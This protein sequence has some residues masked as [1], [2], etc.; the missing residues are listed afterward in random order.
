[1]LKYELLYADKEKIQELINKQRKTLAEV[2]YLDLDSIANIAKGESRNKWKQ[3]FQIWLCRAASYILQYISKNFEN[4][5]FETEKNTEDIRF[6]M[7]S[8][9]HLKSAAYIPQM[10]GNAVFITEE[11]NTKEKTGFDSYRYYVLGLRMG[12]VDYTAKL[13]VGVKDGEAYYDHA[14]TEIEKNS[15]LESIDPINTGF[16]NK[17]DAV[18][19]VKD[20]R[21]LSLLQTNSSKVVDENGEPRVVY[22][23]TNESFLSFDRNKAGISR[24][25]CER[26]GRIGRNIW[27]KFF[28]ERI[29]DSQ[30]AD[31]RKNGRINN[32]ENKKSYSHRRKS[33]KNDAYFGFEQN[34]QHQR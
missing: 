13:V 26:Q 16:A 33:Y 5:N 10:I 14:L 31:G 4:P 18:S 30:K 25:T 34:F 3:S 21:L 7:D 15:L 8:E 29:R 12:S 1:M 22:H 32:L 28:P 11:A 23:G 20:K 6:R 19:A 17:E 24:N 9:A 27:Q 2:E